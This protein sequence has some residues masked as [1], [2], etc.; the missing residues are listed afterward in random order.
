MRYTITEFSQPFMTFNDIMDAQ[1]ALEKL[2]EQAK[3]NGIYT[4]NRY[5]LQ[6]EF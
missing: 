4:A 6:I 1:H 3:D 5:A 2:I